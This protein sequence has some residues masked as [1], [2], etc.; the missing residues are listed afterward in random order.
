MEEPRASALTDDAR[1]TTPAEGAHAPPASE[2]VDG[3]Y[4]IVD[5]IASGET[6]TVHRAEDV[7]LGRDVALKIVERRAE[8]DNGAARERFMSEARAIAQVRSEHVVQLYAF[9]VHRQAYYVAMEYVVGRTL[10]SL[11]TEVRASG[12]RLERSRVLT[13]LRD[14]GR[15]LAALQAHGIVHRD[16][17]PA[18]VLIEAGEGRT[19]LVDFG[20]ARLA[21]AGNKPSPLYVAPEHAISH[22]TARSDVYALAC[23]AFELFTGRAPFHGDDPAAILRAHIM[24]PAPLASA[25]DPT[26]RAVD[27]VFSRALAKDPAERHRD[28]DGFLAEL[29]AAAR[30]LPAPRT[31]GRKVLRALLCEREPSLARVLTRVTERA[32]GQ[33]DAT[34]TIELV[35]DASAFEAA[36]ARRRPDLVIIDDDTAECASRL[37]VAVQ[38]AAG[39]PVEVLLLG[40]R[41]DAPRTRPSGLGFRELGKPLN[42]QLLASVLARMTAKLL[43]RAM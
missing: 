9:G 33:A 8:E 13:I 17:K 6:G 12:V 28:C 24:T 37:V 30:R 35:H 34:V 16:V 31:G 20:L 42:A 19:V 1:L 11:L 26:L 5:L 4:R 21:N 7:W 22:V 29:G 27:A 23:A 15:G 41:S 40:R 38:E 10:E 32:V 18:N 3:R 36:L 39:P 25:I 43:E 14:I 2:L